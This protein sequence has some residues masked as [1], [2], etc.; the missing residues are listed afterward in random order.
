MFKARDMF[1]LKKFSGVNKSYYFNNWVTVE[2]PGSDR[3]CI[4]HNFLPNQERRDLFL[5]INILVYST[6]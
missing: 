3:K 4:V 6:L 5:D 1:P 2:F